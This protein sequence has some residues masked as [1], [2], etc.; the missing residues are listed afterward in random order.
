MPSPDPSHGKSTYT[1]DYLRHQA[2]TRQA[3]RSDQSI[4]QS[5]NLFDD[6]TD[7]IRH[8]QQERFQ[9]TREEYITNPAT[10][11]SLTTHQRDFTPKN[12]R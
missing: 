6:R 3:I 2:P 9:R 1:T 12:S 4:L 8:S 11:D 7:Y 10:L 5:R